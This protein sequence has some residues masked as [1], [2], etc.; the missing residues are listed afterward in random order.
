M[1]ISAHPVEA[2]GQVVKTAYDIY[3]RNKVKSG[4]CRVGRCKGKIYGR[5][6]C[7]AHWKKYWP[8]DTPKA[9]QKAKIPWWK[10][11]DWRKSNRELADELGKDRG[12]ISVVRRTK[13]KQKAKFACK[14]TKV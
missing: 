8:A 11:C 6:V 9:L 3:Y 5:S 2:G 14:L 1:T 4:T 13:A 12:W 10:T 7:E